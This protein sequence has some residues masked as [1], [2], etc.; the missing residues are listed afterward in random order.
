MHDYMHM[1][2]RPLMSVHIIEVLK[3]YF[4]LSAVLPTDDRSRIN[5]GSSNQVQVAITALTKYWF[6]WQS[7]AIINL[8]LINPFIK[9]HE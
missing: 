9:G 7:F 5:R 3:T 4:V 1:Y 6:V 2:V 8:K